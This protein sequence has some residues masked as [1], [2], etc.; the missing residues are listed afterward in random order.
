MPA[1]IEVE[2]LV[3]SF[4]GHRAVNGIDLRV[5]PATVLGLLGPNGAGK[6]TTVRM[7]AT[8]IRPDGG[9]ARVAGF[10]VVEQAHEVRGVIGLTGQYAAV[11][12]EISGWENLY[13][14]ARLHNLPRRRAR[15]RVD[16]L[17]EEFGLA[18][19]AEKPAGRYSGG[20]RRR[21]DLA[22]SMVA[23]PE[24]LYLDE[25]TTGLDPRTR[26]ALWDSVRAKVRE[27][28]AVLLT[29]QYM[30]EAEALAND[31]VVMDHG[32]VVASGTTAELRAQVGEEV[33]RI[34]P[35]DP[36]TLDAAAAALSASGLR[37]VTVDDENDVV[38]L[39][40]SSSAELTR[41]VQALGRSGLA[42]ADIETHTPGLDEVFLTLTSE[43]VAP[44]RPSERP[45]VGGRTP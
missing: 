26:N 31:V 10:D 5:P 42:I 1:A 29:T 17:L 21:L 34:T 4:R 11:D 33:L 35:A 6:T 16:E 38:S 19:H 36:L 22:A 9:S 44:S 20:L 14:I 40:M 25:P 13:L 12:N 23:T 24:V 45:I 43:A 32:E 37:Q 7:L 8:L 3:K 27:G 18:D 15:A 28:T 39:A 30:E 2:G 41:A